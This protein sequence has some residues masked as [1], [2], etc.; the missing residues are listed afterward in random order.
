MLKFSGQLPNQSSKPLRVTHSGVAANSLSEWSGFRRVLL[1]K[2]PPALGSV[3]GGLAVLSCT[4]ALAK[5]LRLQRHWRRSSRLKPLRAGAE[6]KAQA[7]PKEL[8][9]TPACIRKAWVFPPGAGDIAALALREEAIEDPV[10]GEVRVQVQ[11]IGLNF[12][13]V[14]TGL[15]LYGPIASGEVGSEA[16]GFVPGL[17][18]SGVVTSIGIDDRY[19]T[20][21]RAHGGQLCELTPEVWKLARKA[22][23]GFKVGDRVMGVLRFG[24]YASIVNAPAHQ[25]R[26]IPDSW[27]FEEGAAFLVQAMTPSY[28][29]HE[30]GA[31][32][33]GHTVLV[34]SAAGGC[35]LQAIEICLKLGVKVVGTVGSA[36]KVPVLLERFPSLK[37]EQFLV[38]GSG[39]DFEAQL[40]AALLAVGSP[41]GFDI[42]LDAVLGDFFQPGFACLAPGG[43][44]VVYGAA[45]MTPQQDSLG[46]LGWAKLGWQWLQRPWVD[47]LSLPGVN[48]SVMGFNLIHCFNNA[49]LLSVLLEDLL[50]LNLPAP[51]VGHTFRFEDAV[52]ALRTFKT[53]MTTG[54]VVLK[55]EDST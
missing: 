50:N 18:F 15:A 22:A 16:G 3:T 37:P 48:K 10:L 13:D 35:G 14:F 11:A 20:A 52:N 27:S 46:V 2:G 7:Q 4:A 23:T 39:R 5:S 49:E 55:I 1:G 36:S 42:V 19:P 44:Y 24:A 34:Q 41:H 6:R 26:H 33:P 51:R 12:A 30:L 31:M 25:I 54:K 8:P 53:G 21:K 28:A 38:R 40:R 9:M 17:E 47:P 29:L 43:R 45:S 32:R